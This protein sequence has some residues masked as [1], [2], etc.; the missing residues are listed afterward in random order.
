MEMSLMMI[1]QCH[2]GRFLKLS[3]GVDGEFHLIAQ[4]GERLGAFE[5][6]SSSPDHVKEALRGLQRA[7]MMS[8]LDGNG[9]GTNTVMN[10]SG[11]A[12]NILQRPKE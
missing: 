11:F 9:G 5:W 12:V 1:T 4:D 8:N 10:P 7:M 3:E 6:P 2:G